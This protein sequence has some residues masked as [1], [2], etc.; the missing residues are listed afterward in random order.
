LI[1]AVFFIFLIIR[2][3]WSVWCCCFDFGGEQCLCGVRWMRR[4]TVKLR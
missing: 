1:T 3:A 4:K 2:V